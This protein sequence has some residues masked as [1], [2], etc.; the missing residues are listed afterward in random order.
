MSLQ[1]VGWAS[2]SRVVLKHGQDVAG[3]V[4]EPRYRR[5][6]AAVAAVNAFFIGLDRAFSSRSARRACQ[7]VN[8]LADIVD[9]MRTVKVAGV[10]G[11]R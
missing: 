11:L 2:T 9:R 3:R 8:G 5:T 6:F 4:L 1:S 10:V 7:L